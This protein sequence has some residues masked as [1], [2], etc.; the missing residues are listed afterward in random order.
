[1]LSD[2]D[3]EKSIRQSLDRIVPE[4]SDRTWLL[5]R[6]YKHK[7]GNKLPRGKRFNFYRCIENK[8][9]WKTVVDNHMHTIFTKSYKNQVSHFLLSQL[10]LLD[11]ACVSREC[12]LN[13]GAVLDV[14]SKLEGETEYSASTD[15]VKH[16]IKFKRK[17]LFANYKHT[18]VPVL[19][20][21]YLK[22]MTQETSISSIVANTDNSTLD[23]NLL[24][25]EAGIKARGKAKGGRMTGH[26]LIT[27]ENNEETYYLA[28]FPHARTN[29]LDEEWIFNQVQESERYLKC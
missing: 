2:I 7:I 15:L 6:L 3:I 23:V 13:T 9:R 10:T 14:I 20:N 28:I 26:W 17:G 27:R 25:V 24:E 22:M 1:M 18:H 4:V 16:D 5:E 21:S 29:G 19:P 8:A 12:S 11:F